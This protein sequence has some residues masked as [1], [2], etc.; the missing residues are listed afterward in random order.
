MAILY[1][2]LILSAFWLLLSGIF[3]AMHLT[4]GA[5]C[6]LLVSLISHDLLFEESKEE[7]KAKRSRL[8]ASWRFAFYVPWLLWQIFL[9]NLH[10]AY[11][12]LHPRAG[13]LIDP[14]I[15]RFPS[16]LKTDIAKVTL[17][18]SITLT[19]GTITIHIAGDDFFVHAIDEK[20][21]GDLPGDLPGEMEARIARVL[22]RD[23]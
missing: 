12:A 6:C 10:V 1:T 3:D 17:A 13:D 22:E 9:A 7:S 21:A 16:K 23:R 8:A 19:P 20:A 15:I 5:L 18:N 11:L 14:R 4:L 2:F